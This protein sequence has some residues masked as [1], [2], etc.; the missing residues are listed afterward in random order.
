MKANNYINHVLFVIDKSGS[1]SHLTEDVIRV[2]DAQIAH[3]SDRSRELDQETRVTVYLFDSNVEC[4]IY[5]MDV[6]RL[7]SL[8]TLYRAGG[9]TALI[10]ATVQAVEE[11]SETPE[12][13]GDHA[14]LGYVITD[15]Q[16]NAS[17]YRDRSSIKMMIARMHDNWTLGVLVPDQQGVFEAKGFGFPSDNISVWNNTRKGIEEA[18]KTIRDT[19][20]TFMLGRTKGIRKVVNLFQMNTANLTRTNVTRKLAQLDPTEFMIKRVA[21]TAVIKPFVERSMK[22]E[23]SKGCAFYQMTKPEIIQAYKEICVRDRHTGEV[24]SGDN[25][26]SLLGLPNTKAKV[27]PGDHSNYDV[28]VQSTSY[29]RKLMPGTSLLVMLA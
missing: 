28:F 10:D 26:R 15:G 21:A 29:T 1:M 16:E 27:L 2:F 11:L 3:L 9:N 7:P 19:T 6:L 12:R 22:L 14:F 17:R 23:Y 13:Y 18:I 25:A 4:A 20:E 8:R 24:F 5:D